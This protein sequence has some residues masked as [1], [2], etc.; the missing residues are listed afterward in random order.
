MPKTITS[1]KIIKDRV[2]LGKR[3][4]AL[5]IKKGITTYTLQKTWRLRY[6]GV[7]NGDAEYTIDTLLKY[8]DRCGIELS[9][10]LSEI[11]GQ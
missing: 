4:K 2:A 8:C 11:Q 1:D 7:E 6:E 10:D 5:R 9:F 3:L